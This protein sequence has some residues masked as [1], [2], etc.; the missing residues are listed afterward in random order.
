MTEFVTRRDKMVDM[1]D[2]SISETIQGLL[3]DELDNLAGHIDERIQKFIIDPA[4]FSEKDKWLLKERLDYLMENHIFSKM[5]DLIDAFIMA[6]QV[7][8]IKVKYSDADY[9]LKSYDFEKSLEIVLAELKLST[10]KL[11]LR[12]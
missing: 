7:L 1:L 5:N 6:I 11:K 10:T 3:L 9:S 2:T 8:Q 4:P 12:L